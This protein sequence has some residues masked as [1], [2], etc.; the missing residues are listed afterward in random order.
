MR[1]N[2]PRK[3]DL[4]AEVHRHQGLAP[5]C[6][7]KMAGGHVGLALGAEYREETLK[8]SPDAAAIAGDILG[9][10]ITATDGSRDNYGDLRRAARCRSRE[11]SRS[12][13][14]ARYDHYSDY[15]SSTTPKVGVKYTPIDTARCC[16]PT[17]ARASAPRRCRRSRPRSATFFTQ[18]NDPETGAAPADLGRRSP[19][20]RTSRPR[21]RPAPTSA[22]SSS[23]RANFSTSLD[24]Y[25]IKW[26][27]HRPGARASRTSSMRPARTRRQDPAVDP[28][29][30]ST[31]QVLR[32]PVTNRPS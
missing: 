28:P 4:G 15:G 19:A 23:R 11:Q 24:Y 21:S 25:W 27:G 8:D 22:S 5:S 2:V 26:Q 29:C 6:L 31:D 17:G 20:T 9:Q 30:P 18:V 14:P 12:S 7:V 13:S 10:G 3:S 16:A 32:D 1:V